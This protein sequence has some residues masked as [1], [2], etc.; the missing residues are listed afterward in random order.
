MGR[1]GRGMWILE[2][3][4]WYHASM[5][6]KDRTIVDP[7]E[8]VLNITDHM[9]DIWDPVHRCNIITTY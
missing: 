7:I 9:M 8:Q 2:A 3:P 6:I 4:T 5:S 1:S